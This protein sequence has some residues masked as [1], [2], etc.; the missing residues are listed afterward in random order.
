MPIGNSDLQRRHRFLCSADL[1]EKLE[2]RYRLRPAE[3]PHGLGPA[4]YFRL[5]GARG[6]IGFISPLSDHFCR[7]CNRIRLTAD[8]WV[9]TCLLSDRVGVD[10]KTPFRRGARGQDLVDL[11]RE[12]IRLKPA[13][14]DL[15]R[16]DNG[17]G[18]VRTM[19][20][21]GG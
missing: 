6:T 9:R 5:P 8:G 14:H 1:R 18:F 11:F 7:S 13:S 15:A 2:K 12:A 17:G 3:A 21:I 10:V 19:C 4:R 16:S 20:Q